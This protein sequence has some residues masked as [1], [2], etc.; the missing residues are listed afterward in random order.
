[1]P[2]SVEKHI[3]ASLFLSSKVNSLT[4]AHFFLHNQELRSHRGSLNDNDKSSGVVVVVGGV[5]NLGDCALHLCVWRCI[6]TT[7]PGVLQAVGKEKTTCWQQS[8]LYPDCN[9]MDQWSVSPYHDWFNAR[10]LKHFNTAPLFRLR[11][12]IRTMLPVKISSAFLFFFFTAKKR[13]LSERKL[14]DCVTESRA[15]FKVK[16]KWTINVGHLRRCY[17]PLLSSA[18]RRTI[19]V[20]HSVINETQTL[21]V[22]VN[23]LKLL[24]CIKSTLNLGVNAPASKTWKLRIYERHLKAAVVLL[25]PRGDSLS[26]ISAW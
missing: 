9:R 8:Q 26:C 17:N 23:S 20:K 21:L 18:R 6:P 25:P 11:W 14:L 1:M 22:C 13:G 24:V 19:C 4:L 16:I 2:V 15:S 10:T 3:K 7:Y 12:L 5:A